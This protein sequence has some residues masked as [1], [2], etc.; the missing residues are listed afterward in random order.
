[1][2][3]IQKKTK[4][5]PKIKET[6]VRSELNLEKNAVFAVSTYS[7]RSKEITLKE[8]SSYGEI[9]KKI[10]IGKM[11]DGTETGVLT[12]HHFKLYLVLIELWEKAGKPVNETIHFTS[13]QVIK[14][15]GMVDNGQ[16]Y[17]RIRKWLQELRVIPITFLQ[18]FYEPKSG[19]YRDLSYITILNYLRIFERNK[20]GGIEQ[21]RGY[22][23]FQFDRYILQNLLNNYVHPLRLDVITSFKHHKDLSILLY[24]YIDRNLAFQD[25]YEIGLEKL[26]NHLDLSQNHIKYPSGR[27]RVIDPVLTELKG[28]Q[29]STGILIYCAVESTKDGT[30]YKLVCRK[31]TIEQKVRRKV[32]SVG[33]VGQTKN[34]EI[35]NDLNMWIKGV[36]FLEGRDPTQEEIETMRQQLTAQ[37]GK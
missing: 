17:E 4:P 21:T 15:L 31:K 5:V 30:D 33:Q 28:K 7:K 13:Y 1:M 9:E 23:E 8:Q 34:I 12:V 24:A 11:P 26:F 29:L 2:G 27:K 35:E 36:R 20:T 25:K 22:G 18:S 16:S 6:I 19:H 10:I 32:I 3:A 14:R 37:K